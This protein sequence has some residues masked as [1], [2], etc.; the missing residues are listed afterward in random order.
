M[1]VSSSFFQGGYMIVT[2]TIRV[3]AVIGF[4]LALTMG[5]QQKGSAGKSEQSIGQRAEESAKIVQEAG[6][7]I[8]DSLKQVKN[9]QKP[10]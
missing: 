7:R 9:E 5:C 2:R 3:M 1:L 8:Q 10:K 6:K 4:A